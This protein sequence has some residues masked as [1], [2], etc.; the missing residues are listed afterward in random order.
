MQY[1]D[2]VFWYA[3]WH[4]YFEL[5][6][7][8]NT[9]KHTVFLQYESSCVVGGWYCHEPCSCTDH[10]KTS[11]HHHYLE[12]AS[13]LV[14][15]TPYHIDLMGALFWRQPVCPREEKYGNWSL[16]SIFHTVCVSFSKPE[17]Q[18]SLYD[19][20]D[21]H[22]LCYS[23]QPISFSTFWK[24]DHISDNIWSTTQRY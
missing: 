18:T 10:K 21:I 20:H 5:T 12:P 13:L 15:Y 24:V 22:P 11:V 2:A 16:R 19:I 6:C 4:C 8:Y 9:N 1:Q 17:Q 14:D 7:S 3:L 23:P